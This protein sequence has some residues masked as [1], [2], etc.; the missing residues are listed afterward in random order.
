MCVIKHNIHG[1]RMRQNF[2]SVCYV[3]VTQIPLRHDWADQSQEAQEI[4][5]TVEA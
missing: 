3:R 5:A 2:K 1:E 4:E